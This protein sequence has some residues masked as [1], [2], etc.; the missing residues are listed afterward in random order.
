MSGA[1]IS[2]FT[3]RNRSILQIAAAVVVVGAVGAFL[4]WS[5]ST[6]TVDDPWSVGDIGTAYHLS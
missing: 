5:E 4:V 3:Q 6:L 2:S 1:Q